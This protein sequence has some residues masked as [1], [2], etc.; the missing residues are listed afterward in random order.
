MNVVQVR[1]PDNNPVGWVLETEGKS[2]QLK[3]MNFRPYVVKQDALRTRR[4]IIMTIADHKD[5][6]RY[7]EDTV[8]MHDS[9]VLNST[10]SH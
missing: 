6:L 2:I 1:F 9:V 10:F 3:T 8:R 4:S 5:I 7:A